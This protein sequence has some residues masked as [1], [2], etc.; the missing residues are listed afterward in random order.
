MPKSKQETQ[1]LETANKPHL[2]F[3]MSTCTIGEAD[4]E[5]IGS[6]SEYEEEEEVEEDSEEEVTVVERP[7][8]KT[9]TCEY[10]ILSMCY[11][12][13][14]T[15][16]LIQLCLCLNIATT[17]TSSTQAPGIAFSDRHFINQI[18]AHRE[19][20]NEERVEDL[21]N[22]ARDALQAVGLGIDNRNV[23]EFVMD[24]VLPVASSSG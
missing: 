5:D 22:R 11:L 15:L 9:R 21:F 13:D 23:Y 1:F 2:E 17:S 3:P 10:G 7:R 16:Y 24:R 18:I 8:K 14:G 4:E 20:M 6:E 12:N 19:N